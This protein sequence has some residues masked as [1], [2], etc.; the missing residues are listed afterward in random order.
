MSR[1]PGT[2]VP[3]SRPYHW[4]SVSAG[5]HLAVSVGAGAAAGVV[6]GLAVEWPAGALVAWTVAASVFLGWTWVSVWSMDASD[7]ARLTV[8]Q[9]PSR[10]V[11]DLVLLFVAAGSLVAVA[12][13]IFPAHRSGTAR[14]V[15]AVACVVGS[16]AVV[17]T[18]YALKY[19]RLYY[20]NPV[21]GL[22]F[23]QDADP[24]FRDFAYV[25]FTV[26]MTFQVSDTEVRSAAIRST[27]LGHAL[28][29]F[30]FGAIII[31]VTINLVAG[32]SR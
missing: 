23:K 13:V 17:H 2:G 31:A 26:G 4:Q 29:S 5:T 8:R 9:D 25:A 27:V 3:P 18:V 12:L 24:T 7:T 30:L 32:L 28:I 10:T 1:A 15:L 11:R 16:W 22:E 21:G 20:T 19:A 6:L 14:I